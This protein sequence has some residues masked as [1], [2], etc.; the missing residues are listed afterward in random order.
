M[1]D[2]DHE[3]LC[4]ELRN[5]RVR[6]GGGFGSLMFPS[7]KDPPEPMSRDSFGHLLAFC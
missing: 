2:S 6:M 7:D 1:G 4:D 3:E 5:F